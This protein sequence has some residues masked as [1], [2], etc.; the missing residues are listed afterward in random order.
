[1]SAEPKK[2]LDEYGDLLGSLSKRGF[3]L[4]NYSQESTAFDNFCADFSD[5][6]TSFRIIRDRSQV[7]FGRSKAEFGR[8]GRGKLSMID[9]ISKKHYSIGSPRRY[10]MRLETDLRTRSLGSRAVPAQPSR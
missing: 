5:R 10:N 9:P 8:M 6:K 1:M 7:F 4:I 3:K 2:C